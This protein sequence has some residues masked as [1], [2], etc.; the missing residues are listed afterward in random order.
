MNEPLRQLTF[1]PMKNYKK[2]FKRLTLGLELKI[3]LFDFREMILSNF[4]RMILA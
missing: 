2:T 3:F 4:S 1:V